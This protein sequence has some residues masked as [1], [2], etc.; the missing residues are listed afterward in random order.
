MKKFFTL[1]LALLASFSLWAAEESATGFCTL[2]NSYTS[3]AILKATPSGTTLVDNVYLANNGSVSNVKTDKAVKLSNGAV[4]FYLKEKAVVKF[5][6]LGGSSNTSATI[7]GYDFIINNT[8]T[9]DA[10]HSIPEVFRAY[11]FMSGTTNKSCADWLNLNGST[12]CADG[13]TTFYT[14]FSTN[15]GMTTKSGAIK[16]ESKVYNL[17]TSMTGDYASTCFTSNKKYDGSV[18]EVNDNQEKDFEVTLNSG[19]YAFN[20]MTSNT[21][22]LKS[23]TFTSATP[24]LTGAW[25]RGDATVTSDNVMQGSSVTAP[26]FT[27]GATSGDAPTSSDYSV[28]Y[29]LKEGSTAGIFTFTDGVPTAISST[30]AG[31]ATV[32]ATLTT[33]APTKYLTPETN[34]FEYTVNVS[35]AAA[36]AFTSVTPNPSSN[37]ARGTASTIEAVVTGTPTPTIQWYSCEDTKK[38]NP[39]VVPGATDLTLNLANTAVGIYYYYAVASNTTTQLNEVASDVVTITVKPQAPTL[40]AAGGFVESKSV[41]ITK[42]D[43]EAEGAAIKYSTDDGETWNAYSEALTITATTT[44]QAK[45]EQSGISSEVVSA[46]YTKVTPKTQRTVSSSETWDWSQATG[47]NVNLS[48]T[49]TPAKD[50][51]L[52]VV[53][54]NFDGAVY[55]WDCKFPENFDAIVMYKFQRPKNDT[56]YQGQTIKIHTDVTGIISVQFAN[57]GNKRPNRYLSV[58]GTIYGEGSGDESSASKRTV[59][60][61]VAAGDIILTG[62]YEPNEA[63]YEHAGEDGYQAYTPGNAGTAQYLNYY[64]ITFTPTYAVTFGTPEGGTLVVKQ[65]GVAITSGDLFEEGTVLT[66]EATPDDDHTLTA[67]TAGEEDILA[68]KQFTVGTS[69]VTVSATFTEKP[70]APISWMIGEDEITELTIYLD[71]E[72][73]LPTL[74]NALSL[75]VDLAST[76]ESVAVFNAGVLEITGVGNATISAE[77]DGNDT[78]KATTASYALNVVEKYPTGVENAEAGMKAVK[79]LKNGVLI[80]E[81]NGKKYNVIGSEIR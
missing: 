30:N 41:T 35:A 10:L 26:T 33:A 13:T 5:T 11:T 64:K 80:I 15:I 12:L 40:T 51:D 8:T 25:K 4:V 17:F 70:D 63:N 3:R 48:N 37:I 43:G 29:S 61:P 22:G 14:F 23:V 20:L 54:S 76:N 32:V 74:S 47:V 42:A 71:K 1:T 72:Y 65:G 7:N 79:S 50:A 49:T 66:V 77:F 18:T 31:S 59:E 28:V 45:V 2:F 56:Y 6:F 81:K 9:T 21:I 38:T 57:T 73:T 75:T 24:T 34:T 52:D 68:S 16:S 36:P 62:I 58:N 67:L 60:V 27:V 44:V 78:Y 19:Y 53:A 39:A 46:T 55:E 69:A